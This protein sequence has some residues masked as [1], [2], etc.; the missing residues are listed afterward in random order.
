M[1][2]QKG[3]LLLQP[4]GS[5]RRATT[6]ILVSMADRTTGLKMDA[7]ELG[8]Q[9]KGEPDHFSLATQQ[10]TLTWQPD[11]LLA[12]GVKMKLH[13]FIGESYNIRVTGKSFDFNEQSAFNALSTAAT[14]VGVFVVQ[15]GHGFSG[16]EWVTNTIDGYVLA[17]PDDPVLR[18]TEGRV[19]N[20]I[21]KD[22][23]VLESYGFGCDPLLTDDDNFWDY[24]PG[25]ELILAADGTMTDVKPTDR[26]YRILG[27]IQSP[28]YFLIDQKTVYPNNYKPVLKTWPTDAML[29]AA[30]GADGFEI[31]YY[32]GAEAGR[33]IGTYANFNCGL[34][35][36][37]PINPPVR[38]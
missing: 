27:H 7:A 15:P 32:L 19:A 17:Q 36:T 33:E 10:N 1:K 9:V 5:G 34:A 16:T 24:D 12:V 22:V 31:F 2:V 21:D 8:T 38:L 37:I 35:A 11:I 3:Q 23:F 20:V 26:P 14:G 6:C 18:E 4:F 29:R 25:T 30:L 28:G 13:G